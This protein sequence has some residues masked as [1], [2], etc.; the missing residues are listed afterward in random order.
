MGLLQNALLGR[1]SF[2]KCEV[3]HL[4]LWVTIVFAVVL[5][6]PQPCSG[7][8]HFCSGNDMSN[9]QGVPRIC[10][11]TLP[12]RPSLQRGQPKHRPLSRLSREVSAEEACLVTHAREYAADLACQAG[13]AGVL[14]A[15]SDRLHQEHKSY[16]A[17]QVCPKVDLL[18]PYLSLQGTDVWKTRAL[19]SQALL[20]ICSACLLVEG[21]MTP[22]FGPPPR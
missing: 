3:T 6:F 7:T 9:I 16:L 12:C 21:R 2:H 19:Y 20:C 10:E 5:C 18:A 14:R 22:V 11:F 13:T 17:A 15:A 4:L 1:M 8:C